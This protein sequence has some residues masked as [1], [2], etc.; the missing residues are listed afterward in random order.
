MSAY[1]LCGLPFFVAGM[2]T[3]INGSYMAPLYDTKVGNMLIATG[4]CMMAVGALILK[5]IVS[6]KG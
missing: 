2:L 4:L 3:L 1:V 5:K 6:F